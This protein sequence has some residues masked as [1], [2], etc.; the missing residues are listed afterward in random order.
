VWQTALDSRSRWRESFGLSHA[1]LRD[2]G[3]RLCQGSGDLAELVFTARS[4][5]VVR[6][7][8]AEV[9]RTADSLYKEHKG[10][11]GVA[12]RQAYAD[13]E[14][15]RLLVAAATA[16]AQQVQAARWASKQ[17]A[18]E[19][20]RAE[21]RLGAARVVAVQGDQRRRAASDA[22]LL[23]GVQAQAATVCSTGVALGD[24]Q[25]H[26]FEEAQKQLAAAD[27]AAAVLDGEF[28]QLS[29]KRTG[30]VVEDA[31]LVDGAQIR[32]LHL[33]SEARLEDGRRAGQLLEAAATC[34]RE[35]AVLLADLA[36]DTDPRPVPELL[37]AL[38][39]PADRVTQLDGLGEQLQT[40]EQLLA[41]REDALQAATRR[42]AND[43]VG[44]VDLET[45]VVAAVREAHDAIQAAGSAVSGQRAAVE[46]H[47][48]G[49]RRRDEA[50]RLAGLPTGASVPATVPSATAIRQAAERLT[51]ANDAVKETG[52]R[53]E[54]EL[55][56]LE[57]TGR[58][59][60]AAQDGDIPGANELADARGER[61]VAVAEQRDGSVAKQK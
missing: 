12:V 18:D 58:D 52:Q 42:L 53:V 28:A 2:G 10:N 17:A 48:D 6:G 41:V 59:L 47:A 31:I 45:D 51:D 46:A 61:D 24:Q 3:K 5:R 40:G 16:G 13:Y 1:E 7:L 44:A 29:K 54:R 9:Q 30:V 37:S 25:L 60:A 43:D 33:E 20:R 55:S 49:Q 27:A 56:S 14:Q 35:A 8:L 4:G 15:A 11:K 36:G 21:Q 19:V 39:V 57:A 50:L 34:G 23:A 38:H 26:E 32:R 22:R